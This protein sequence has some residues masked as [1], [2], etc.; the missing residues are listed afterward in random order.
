MPWK[1]GNFELSEMSVRGLL[2]LAKLGPSDTFV[3]LGSG[4]GSVVIEAVRTSPVKRAIG[5]EIESKS[6][7]KARQAAFETLTREQLERVDFWIG[8]IYSED[9]D[10][11]AVTTIYNSFEED[12]E[13]LGLYRKRFKRNHL[14][15]LK[16]DLPFV[17]YAPK[18][19]VRKG[20]TWLFR[21][22]FPLSRIRRKSEWASMV[23]GRP[24]ASIADIYDYYRAVLFKRGISRRE[25]QL[26]LN[27]LE[28]LVILRF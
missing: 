24:N 2:D 20:R 3:D 18:A 7:E 21:T 4:T 25:I 27:Q 5:V 12:E 22:D 17:G 16:K 1:Y 15:V 8:D 26:A 19:A 10:Y 6:R 28:R 14:R 11:E 9:F 13:E 23:L